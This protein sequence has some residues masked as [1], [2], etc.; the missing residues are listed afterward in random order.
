MRV[1]SVCL[2]V[3]RPTCKINASAKNSNTPEETIAKDVFERTGAS[4]VSFGRTMQWGG[5]LGT[6]VGTAAGV[7]LAIATGGATLAAT[8]F[9]VGGGGMAGDAIDAS[10]SDDY[11]SSDD[12]YDS[13]GAEYYY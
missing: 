12:S 11:P 7:G 1:S 3:S 2:A 13:Y 10:I 5:L 9:L 6:I 4:V 8:P